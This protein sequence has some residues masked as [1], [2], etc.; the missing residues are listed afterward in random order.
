MFNDVLSVISVGVAGLDEGAA[1]GGAAL[2]RLDWQPA[3]DATPELA[4]QL[5]RLS[6]DRDDKECFGSVIDRANL[7]AV[8]RVIGAEPVW[9]DVALHA[10]DVLPDLGRTLLHAGPPIGWERMCGP[11]RGAVIGAI[12]YEG[13]ASSPDRAEALARS[14]EVKFAPCHEHGAVGPMSGIISPSMPLVVVRNR[15]AGNFAYAPFMESG[16]PETLRFGAYSQKVLDGLRWIEQTVAPTLRAAVRGAP[17]GLSLKPIIAQAL[18]MGD[19]VHNRNT[20][21]SLILLRWVACELAA[22]GLGRETVARVLELIRNDDMFF[23]SLS[24]AACKSTMD[25]AHGV[26][27]SSVVTAMAR[28]G[29]EV[30]IRVSGLGERWFTGPADIPKGLYLPGFSEADANPDIGDSAITE[31]A[32]LGAFAMAAAPAMVQFVGGKPSDALRYSTEMKQISVARNPGFT[33]PALDF[34]AAP[35]GIDVRRVLDDGSRPV[36]NTATAHREPGRGIIG[37]GIV[38]AP[39]AC[40]TTAL[41]ALADAADKAPASHPGERA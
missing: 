30:G 19:D 8:D 1:S 10:R 3:G 20:A 36:I 31:T 4:W 23:L 17:D 5:A 18:H 2:T 26:P 34:V 24:M 15:T 14:G 21:A 32:G 7:E 25:A 40:F 13:W 22:G 9:T 37:A 33:L 39:L 41:Y 35:V 27:N 29:V 12:L 6:G 38:R 28:N 11:M 16:G